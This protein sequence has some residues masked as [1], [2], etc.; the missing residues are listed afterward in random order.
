MENLTLEKIK[1]AEEFLKFMD[2]V[3]HS[4]KEVEKPEWRIKLGDR[5]LVL[6]LNCE[7]FQV[8]Y[9]AIQEI[10]GISN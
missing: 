6:P 8:L 7:T 9:S 3:N 1:A 2:E 10:A 5:E 4:I